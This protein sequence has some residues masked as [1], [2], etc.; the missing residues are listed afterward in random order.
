[1]HVHGRRNHHGD[2]NSEL[3]VLRPFWQL[4]PRL[5]SIAE[6]ALLRAEGLL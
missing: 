2:G 4:V 1:M 3:W 5:A 6:V